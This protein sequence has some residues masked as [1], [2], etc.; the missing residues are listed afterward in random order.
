VLLVRRGGGA[1]RRPRLGPLFRLAGLFVFELFA[2]AFAVAALALR[3]DLRRLLRP[4][5]VA[6]PLTATTDGEI[7]ILA[8]LITLT[9]GTL[10]LDVSA[11]RRFLY[12]HVLDLNDRETLRRGIADGF[13]RTVLEVF[14]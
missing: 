1:P 4:A 9:P 8:N 7:T 13:E 3:P 12:V 11:D 2:G 5:I 14:K 10:T 6:F